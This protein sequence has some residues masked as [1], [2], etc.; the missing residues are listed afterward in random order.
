MA[1]A[2]MTARDWARIGLGAGLLGVA[3]IL[4]SVEVAL[5]AAGITGATTILDTKETTHDE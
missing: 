1:N 2:G 4:R 3:V 5:A